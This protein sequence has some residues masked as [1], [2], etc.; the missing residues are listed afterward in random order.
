MEAKRIKIQYTVTFDIEA[1]SV[2]VLE[3]A[4]NDLLQS[5]STSLGGMSRI[6]GYYTYN[7]KYTTSKLK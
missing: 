6:N 5:G 2:E 3:K 1:D 7:R 4:V